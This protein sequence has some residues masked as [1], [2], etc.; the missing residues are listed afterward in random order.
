MNERASG[1]A[2]AKL[3]H[4]H[5]A[6]AG[7]RRDRTRWN[8]PAGDL[9]HV[10]DVQTSKSLAD[11]TINLGVFDPFVDWAVWGR[12]PK[13]FISEVDCALRTRLG[14]LIDG[15]DGPWWPLDFASVPL[16]QEVLRT[17]GLPWLDARTERTRIAADLT[18]QGAHRGA[19]PLPGLMLAAMRWKLGSRAEADDLLA[20]LAARVNEGWRANIEE[21]RSRL[22]SDAGPTA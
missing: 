22:H 17:V 12:D 9:V 10:I 11:A 7:F 18:A 8:R 6:S 4:P 16:M 14:P 13:S 5:L 20:A 21:T 1:L 2:I 15:H 3:L 19:Y